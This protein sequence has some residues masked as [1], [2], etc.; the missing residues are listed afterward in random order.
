MESQWLGCRSDLHNGR[1]LTAK[2]G[3]QP[4]KE[5][6][7]IKGFG[8]RLNGKSQGADRKTWSVSRHQSHVSRWC[9]GAKGEAMGTRAPGSVEA[10]DLLASPAITSDQ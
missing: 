2:K 1:S 8:S 4:T 5:G 10:I 6:L 3:P 9:S 7:E